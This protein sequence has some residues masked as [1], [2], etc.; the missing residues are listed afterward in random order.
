MV[1]ITR[2]QRPFSPRR[3][4]APFIYLPVSPRTTVDG[5]GM[6]AGTHTG[7][8][9]TFR[10]STDLTEHQCDIHTALD[11]TPPKKIIEPGTQASERLRSS[12]RICGLHPTQSCRTQARTRPSRARIMVVVVP[13]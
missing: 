3:R 9:R 8:A 2:P 11:L 7:H 1:Q 12:D 6:H 13:S 4:G 5:P 10:R